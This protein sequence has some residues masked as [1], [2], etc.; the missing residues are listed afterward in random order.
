MS[1]LLDIVHS[2][3]Q[4]IDQGKE[5]C[6]VFFD[7]QKAF[8][9]V[10]HKALIEVY[11]SKLLRWVCSHLLSTLWKAVLNGAKSTNS[12]VIPQDSV[13]G[14]LLFIILVY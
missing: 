14:P 12:Q 10:P 2:W 9:S 5:V 1:A 8:D 11:R 6:A 7:L 3:S 13:L 4:A